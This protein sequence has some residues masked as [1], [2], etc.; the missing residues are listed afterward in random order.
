M[1]H[2]GKIAKIFVVAFVAVFNILFIFR[3]CVADY[4]GILSD[5]VPT[6]A[7]RAAYADGDAGLITH[8]VVREISENGYMRAYAYVW[9][10]EAREIQV[11]V[12]Y[13]DSVWEYNLLP[14]DSEF[15][16][17]LTDSVTGT[18]WTPSYTE[19]ESLWM[20]NYRRLVFSDVEFPENA[21]LTVHMM[22][23]DQ[24]I[25]AE[26]VH[27]ADQNVVNEPY[28]LSSQEKRSLSTNG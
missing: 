28:A 26:T 9:S 17:T 24:E 14:E 27:Y 25:S 13:N 2:A 5:V 4:T 22:Y 10:P 7:L 11:T 15:T 1:K 8:D 3:C 6:E 20:Y 21:N 16:Y 19:E 23:G 12:R 18:T